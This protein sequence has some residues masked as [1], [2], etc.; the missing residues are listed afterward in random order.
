MKVF[1]NSSI[2][3]F[4][5]AILEIVWGVSWALLVIAIMAQGCSS[6]GN[7]NDASDLVFSIPCMIE[8]FDMTF[9]DS[10]KVSRESGQESF[11]DKIGSRVILHDS[12][13]DSIKLRNTTYI[14]ECRPL[15]LLY[16]AICKFFIIIVMGSYFLIIYNLRSI[17]ATLMEKAP[18]VK[19]NARRL[20]IIGFAITS[21]IPLKWL[22]FW[23]Y[24]VLVIKGSITMQGKPI[25]VDIFSQSDL[26]TIFLGLVIVVISEV[27][28]LGVKMKENY[29]ELQK[30]MELTV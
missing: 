25:S 5:Y 9:P 30:D 16:A 10:L 1:K 12:S 29:E 17:I 27:F 13:I 28:R 4:L 8:S 6:I 2:A 18:F 3:S 24:E 20:L 11:K 14:L 7:P 26:W 15:N 21:I 22:L 19:E 23:L